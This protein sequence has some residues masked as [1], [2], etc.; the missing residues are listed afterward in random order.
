MIMRSAILLLM[1]GATGCASTGGTAPRSGHATTVQHRNTG[2]AVEGAG[3]DF[4][5]SAALETKSYPV[6]AP[7]GAVWQAMP[8]AYASLDIPLAA[9]DSTTMTVGNPG[10]ALRNGRIAGRRM[11]QYLNCGMDPLTGAVADRADIRLSVLSHV[12]EIDGAAV[13]EVQVTG[14]ASQ[15]GL[16]NTSVTCTSTGRLEE[17]L[18]AAAKLQLVD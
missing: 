11:S 18:A 16:S 13:I 14:S 1:L 5:T 3:I 10:L 7:A 17:A 12:R 4:A 6:G 2:V 15:R 9:L 8:A